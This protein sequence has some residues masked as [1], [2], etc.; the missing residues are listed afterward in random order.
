M[1]AH[2]Q[3]FATVKTLVDYGIREQGSMRF[4]GR[5]LVANQLPAEILGNYVSYESRMS[6]IGKVIAS[7]ILEFYQAQN[8]NNPEWPTAAIK[9]NRDNEF[10]KS[11]LG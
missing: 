8:P 3:V 1:T 2:K 9:L 4:L 10:V 7:G 11:V 5:K 6:I